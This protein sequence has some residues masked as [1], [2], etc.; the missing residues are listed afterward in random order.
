[1]RDHQLI[2]LIRLVCD[3]NSIEEIKFTESGD[4][5]VKFYDKDACYHYQ[6]LTAGEKLI[7]LERKP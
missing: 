5:L 6:M 4:M 7:E 1:M 2:Y 3:E